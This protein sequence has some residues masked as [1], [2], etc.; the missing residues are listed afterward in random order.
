MPKTGSRRTRPTLRDGGGGDLGGHTNHVGG[1]DGI[2]LRADGGTLPR[3]TA[4]PGE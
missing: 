1:P 2:L 4:H 3:V